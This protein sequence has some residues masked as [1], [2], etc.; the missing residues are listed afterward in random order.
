LLLLF[1][2]TKAI[3]QI[4]MPD[5]V[6]IGIS[7]I[8]KVNSGTTPSTYTW[9]IDGLTQGSTKNDISIT[10]ANAGVHLLTV[11]EHTI[12]GCDGDIKSG[13]V[14]V[15]PQPVANAGPDAIVCFGNSLRLTGS[16]GD[17]YQWFPSTY[18]SNP[19]MANPVVTI[20]VAGTYKYILSVSTFNGCKSLNSDTV[21]VTILPIAKV[22]AG[23]DTTVTINQPLQLNAIDVNNSRFV[24]Y[25]WSPSAGLNNSFIKNPVAVFTNTAGNNGTTYTITART[26]DGC[27]AK[28]D[29]NIKVFIKP[30][31]YV[32]TAFTPNG[33]GLNDFVLVIPV[34]IKEL[35]YFSIYNRWGE[36]VFSTKNA[37]IGWDGIYNG[38]QQDG[39]V[40]VWMA[41]GVDYNGNII[42][43]KGTLALLR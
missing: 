24:N 10:W 29:I 31:L 30:E 12:N 25:T 38:K 17:L 26:A 8:Y 23:N 11:Q 3:A 34:G 21:S 37:L 28:D 4:A 6:C 36:L 27:E 1:G 20:P 15:I 42:S 18:L 32:P 22:F 9:K 43:K 16:G 41:E 40:F 33:D 7:R 14:F 19:L 39:H 2:T 13:L 5:T 35:K